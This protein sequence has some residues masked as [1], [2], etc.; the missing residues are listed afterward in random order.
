MATGFAKCLACGRAQSIL[1]SWYCNTCY[2]Y[3]C[4]DCYGPYGPCPRCNTKNVVLAT[5]R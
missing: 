2:R 1:N 3:L 4:A 5:F